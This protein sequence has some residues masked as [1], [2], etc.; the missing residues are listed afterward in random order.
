MLG[1]GGSNSGSGVV[2]GGGSE[3]KRERMRGSRLQGGLVDGGRRVIGITGHKLGK[4][5]LPF[6]DLP[7]GGAIAV[8][9]QLVIQ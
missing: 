5:Q 7:K 8:S 1:S 9:E 6:S 4:E 2:V 3:G